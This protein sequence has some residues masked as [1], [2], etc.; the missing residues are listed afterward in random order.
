MLL[1][2][3]FEREDCLCRLVKLCIQ[4]ANV[5]NLAFGQLGEQELVIPP[6]EEAPHLCHERLKL[7]C[8]HP[9]RNLWEKDTRI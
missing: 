2:R 7:V 8:I 3:C 5:L 1:P 4:D 9:Q 6:H